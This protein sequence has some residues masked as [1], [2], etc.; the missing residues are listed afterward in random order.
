MAQ[1]PS[2]ERIDSAI[3]ALQRLAE[4]VV[5]RRRQ[6]AREVGLSEAEWRLLEEIAAERFMPSLF[7]GRRDGPAAG[8]SRV[9]GGPAEADP[10]ALRDAL[11]L[12]RMLRVGA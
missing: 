4:V 3:G 2:R 8:F 6:L 7:A 11:P 10:L 12:S 9:V 1:A 5:E